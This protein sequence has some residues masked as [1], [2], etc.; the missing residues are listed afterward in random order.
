MDQVCLCG[1]T[2]NT[3]AFYYWNKMHSDLLGNA[4]GLSLH[5]T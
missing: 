2:D 3:N 4:Y 1:L 5:V